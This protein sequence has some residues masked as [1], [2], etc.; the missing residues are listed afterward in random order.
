MKCVF[1]ILCC[2]KGNVVAGPAT[3]CDKRKMS[4]GTPCEQVGPS[5]CCSAH[6][7]VLKCYPSFVPRLFLKDMISHPFGSQK[8]ICEQVHRLAHCANH[9]VLFFL[10]QFAGILVV[11]DFVHGQTCVRAPMDNFLPTVAQLEVRQ[12]CWWFFSLC[13]SYVLS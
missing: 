3:V 6:A 12:H 5:Y 13:S 4:P 8:C 11:M 9:C 10:Q 7:E 2:W 1:P